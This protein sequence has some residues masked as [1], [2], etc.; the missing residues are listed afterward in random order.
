MK[1]FLSALLVLGLALGATGCGNLQNSNLS[2][3]ATNT[4]KKAKKYQ[5]TTTTKGGYTVLLKNGKYQVSPINGISATN[6]D[7]N[8]DTRSLEKGLL[9]LST[10]QF[11]AN[12]YVFQ[13]GQQLSESTVESWL[14]RSTKKDQTGLNPINNHKKSATARN[15]IRVEQILE[16]DFLTG[17]GRNYH[18]GGMSLGIA[19]NSID[20]YNKVTDGPQYHTTISRAD[21]EKYGKEAAEKV[22]KRLRKR[23]KLRS[24]PI[25]IGLFSKTGQDSL[26]GG[27]YFAYGI[28]SAN[29]S[30]IRYWKTLNY[31]TQTLPTVDDAKAINSDDESD[32]S[33]FKSAIQDYFP[34]ISGVTANV[35]YENGKLTEENISV[36][37]QFYGYAQIQSFT[38]L[39]LSAARKYLPSNVA[40]EIKISSVNEVQ[41]VIAKNSPSDNYYVHVFNGE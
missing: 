28:A 26:T 9:D 6:N 12:S 37:T 10:R 22:V 19:M 33:N 38:K 1:R 5:T 31:K 7:N 39:A 24:I 21:Q 4:E 2:N 36:T 15:P 13:E 17:S 29:S 40:I 27:T 25:L 14:A 41:A 11:S 18:L 23:K 16:Q 35:R 34:D 32:F 3:N 8:I 20:Y 30:K